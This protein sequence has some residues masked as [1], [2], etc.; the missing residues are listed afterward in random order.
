M[1]KFHGKAED[2]LLRQVIS[3]KNSTKKIMEINLNFQYFHTN[4]FAK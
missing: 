4:N 3:V 1:V 2:E